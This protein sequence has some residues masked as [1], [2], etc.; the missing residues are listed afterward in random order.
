MTQFEGLNYGKPDFILMDEVSEEAF[1]SNLQKRF[2]ANKIYTY[3]GET[4]VSVNPYKELDIYNDQTVEEYRNRELFERP[5]HVFA[6]ADAAFQDMK[7]RQ[8]DSCIVI[9]GESGA[10]KTEASKIIMRYI[11]KVTSHHAQHEVERV[12]NLLLES[13]P[14]LESFGNA[15]TN[16]ND[17]SSRFGKYMDINFDFKSDPL[18]GRIRTYLLEKARVIRQQEGER[19]FHVF[20]HALG[21]LAQEKLDE[22]G[23]VA[24]PMSYRYL[25]GGGE[26]SA[27]TK[28]DKSSYL[29]AKA[30]MRA[31]KFSADD[32]DAIWRIIAAVLHLGN[33]EVEPSS[34]GETSLIKNT[35]LLEPVAKVLGTTVEALSTALTKR[36][37]ATRGEV[38][39]A[40]L[41]ASVAAY[42]RDALSKAMY[43]RLFDWVVSKVN[44]SVEMEDTGV[45]YIVIGVLDIYGFEIFKLNSFE[46]FC[47]NYCNEKLQQ[48]FIQLV[49]KREQEEYEREGIEWV[50]IDYFNNEVICKLVDSS[51]QGVFNIMDE[52]CLRP[53]DDNDERILIHMDKVH[54]KHDHYYSHA[55]GHKDLKRGEE[56]KI[57][58]YAGDVVYS[59]VGFMDKNKDTFFQDLKRLLYHCSL[60]ALKDMWPEGANPAGEVTKRP[61]TAGTAFKTS[62]IELVTYLEQK[63]PHYVRCVKPNG[64]KRSMDFD[65]D[66]SLHQVRY[67]GLVENVRVRRAGYAYRQKYEIFLR[68]YKFLCP[69]TW[70]F[71]ADRDDKAGTR[72]LVEQQHMGKLVV[73]G[74][75]KLFI[76]NPRTLFSLERERERHL[77]RVV[78]ILQR[79]WR[80]ARVRLA[81]RRARAVNRIA[82]KYRN[83]KTQRWFRQLELCFKNVNNMPDFGKA[84]TW[85]KPPQVLKRGQS[86]IQDIHLN[87]WAA[88]VVGKIPPDQ[89]MEM[90]LKCFIHGSLNRLKRE[91]GYG[92]K[93]LGNG[94]STSVNPDQLQF[95]NALTAQLTLNRDSVTYYSAHVVKLNR[96]LKMDRRVF[97]VTNQRFYRMDEHYQMK[98]KRP[99]E[100]S[101]ITGIS[102]SSGP[103]SGIVIHC[104][105]DVGGDCVCYLPNSRPAAEL[106]AALGNAYQRKMGKDLKVVVSDSIAYNI[107]GK[108]KTLTFGS[109][110]RGF[111]KASANH[112]ILQW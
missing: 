70:P 98:K 108:E 25:S 110:P 49:L 94:L 3:I 102:L 85:P 107:A 24:D 27:V 14:I 99:V 86:Y 112:C 66:L 74:K 76:S 83:F 71:P 48:L 62:M 54:A 8:R 5:P 92:E 93:W 67:L 106:A 11:A 20:Y 45:E 38:V 100:F 90:R 28:N 16:R 96:S 79:V 41:N 58:H 22:L 97:V 78:L 63:E 50:H 59:V 56:F 73:F 29:Q 77:F 32:Q 2:E 47:I 81:L 105:A 37:L 13:N 6:L 46:Q 30:A 18:G 75:T 39:V 12:K 101:S 82:L 52:E 7:W 44:S 43:Q 55:K 34:D 57:R 109:G 69:A 17:N 68:R 33:V 10:G 65:H 40:N 80:G 95:Q 23:L 42:T 51:P 53:G 19:N 64:K 87:W 103:D 60:P 36:T 89:Q 9:S 61:V 26:A 84:V 35:A 111:R 4:I 15:R 21:G 72:L 91:W 88:K 31:M 1:M 104:T